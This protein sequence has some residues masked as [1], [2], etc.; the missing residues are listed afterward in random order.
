MSAPQAV[1][2][3]Y[4]GVFT[5]SPFAAATRAFAKAGVEPTQG[6]SWIFGPYEADTDHP[7]HRLERGELS[8]SA[9]RDEI[10]AT[11]ADAGHDLDPWVVLAELAGGEHRAWMADVLVA[12]HRAGLGTAIVTNNIAEFASVWQAGLPMDSVD[13][14][15]DSSAVGV[16]KPNPA[17]Y[18]L[19]LERLGVDNPG[20]AVFID[21]AASNVA[22]ARALGLV[23]VDV[24]HDGARAPEAALV[25]C[26]LTG[27]APPASLLAV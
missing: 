15:V 12:I 13:V 26:E 4:G 16:R 8:A 23:G 25:L 6:L 3:D 24:D 27:I 20:A 5:T 2:F 22:A 7:W 11:M 14:L 19:A 10:M 1:L 18:R 9:A 21:D 17:I